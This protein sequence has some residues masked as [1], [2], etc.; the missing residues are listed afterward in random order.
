MARGVLENADLHA[1]IVAESHKRA[2]EQLSFQA[3]RAQLAKFF[4]QLQESYAS[5]PD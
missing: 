2:L 3:I 5:R 4:A 1:T